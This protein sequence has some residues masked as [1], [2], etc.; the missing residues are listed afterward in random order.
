VTLEERSEQPRLATPARLEED[1]SALK[2][3]M[4]ML[5]NPAE[6]WSDKVYAERIVIR[7]F[8][9]Q[10]V[11]NVADPQTVQDILL[12]HE[13]LFQ[14]SPIQQRILTTAVGRSLLTLTGEPWKRQRR[15]AAPAFR[16]D[17]LDAM[18]PAMVAAGE[19]A[20][21]RL[22]ERAGS[23]A[24][25]V[26]ADMNL[27][28]LDV[29]LA[30]IL[31]GQDAGLDRAET[32]RK[33]EVLLNSIGR[34]DIFDLLRV[35]AWVPRPWGREG[36]KAVKWIHEAAAATISARR[37][38]K[39]NI[40]DLLGMMLAASS[41]VTGQGLTDDELRDNI[42]TFIGA[43]HETTSLALT[44]S[45]YL[46]AHFPDWQT[47]L[48]DEI[49]SVSG[50]G[51]IEVDHIDKLVLHDRVLNEAMRLYPPAP[52]LGRVAIQD[53]KLDA[54]DVRRGDVLLLSIM[55]MHRHETLWE[56]PDMFDPDRFSPEQRK[57][58]HRFQ[59]LPFSGGPHVCI[60]M[61][62]AMMEAKVILAECLRKVSVAP[63]EGH[64]PEIVSRITLRPRGG[65]PLMISKR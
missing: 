55:P 2:A 14:K 3:L 1:A 63:I 56:A 62:F 61:R 21:N 29:I 46:L 16:H 42:V 51:P 49:A 5:S 38:S 19:G 26:L 18:V 10:R 59:F 37:A 54:L 47:R 58:H 45:L 50:G 35:P 13:P 30:T 52:A 31:S 8:A 57:S 20:A 39:D 6:M 43:G 53:L 41:P 15:A 22:L 24:H 25:D 36:R 4:T 64:Q 23:S 28:T 32:L 17:R 44:W 60:G 27:A 12:T 65:M 33:V 40:D 34:A 9:G 11:I 48:S 7:R